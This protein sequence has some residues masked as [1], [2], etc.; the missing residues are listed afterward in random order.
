MQ[1]EVDIALEAELYLHDDPQSSRPRSHRLN[2]LS[3]AERPPECRVMSLTSFTVANLVAGENGTNSLDGHHY[4]AAGCSDAVI[5]QVAREV[6]LKHNQAMLMQ[7]ADLRGSFI[8]GF[9]RRFCRQ[10]RAV[11][12]KESH[13]PYNFPTLSTGC[14]KVHA[15][16][17]T[18]GW[19]A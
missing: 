18:M 3:S 11:C 17:C 4:V 7:P 14:M 5:R 13:S 12:V 10:S 6:C 2:K 8:L 15:K 16:L 19:E 1:D 9:R